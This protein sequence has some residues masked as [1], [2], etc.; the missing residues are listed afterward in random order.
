MASLLWALVIICTNFCICCNNTQAMDKI[1]LPD[2][3]DKQAVY[4]RDVIEN[5][6]STRT[7]QGQPITLDQLGYILW[8]AYGFRKDGGRVVPSGGGLYP[9]DI[10]VIQGKTKDLPSGLLQ[11]GIYHYSPREREMVLIKPGDFRR[12]VA[13]ASLSQMWMA[14][15][16][17][18]IAIAVE[19]ARITRK[20][21]DRGIRYAHMESGNVSQ[22]IFL[23]ATSHG[24]KCGIVGAFEDDVVKGVM[25]LPRTH[26]P[27]LIMPIGY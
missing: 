19:Y 16:P 9:L 20:Y 18:M 6:H 1:K 12:E 7:F 8:S 15:A 23:A 17:C 3:K 27:L 4:L 22:N 5:R 21:G 13:K 24:L 10:Y 26:E 14:S 25:G 11:S 2:V